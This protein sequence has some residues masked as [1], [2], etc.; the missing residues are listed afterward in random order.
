MTIGYWY[1]THHPPDLQLEEQPTSTGST[2]S[3]TA[4][5]NTTSWARHL[6]SA[7]TAKDNDLCTWPSPR[8]HPRVARP[9]P[10]RVWLRE[11]MQ[12]RGIQKLPLFCSQA[13]ASVVSRWRG[14]GLISCMSRQELR[15]RG[16][17][18]PRGRNVKLESVS[19]VCFVLLFLTSV[20]F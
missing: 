10:A 5:L 13:V 2:T 14:R 4:N 11:T 12:S 20:G 19:E 15:G 8:N 6:S 16:H 9:L 7:Y 1:K 3:L 18:R 17:Q